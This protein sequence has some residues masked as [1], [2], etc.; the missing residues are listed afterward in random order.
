MYVMS[1]SYI[2]KLKDTQ[3]QDTDTN[4]LGQYCGNTTM[5]DLLWI[6][7]L[8]SPACQYASMQSTSLQVYR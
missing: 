5:L 8:L 6:Y 1:P 2:S 7:K 3:M 4:G